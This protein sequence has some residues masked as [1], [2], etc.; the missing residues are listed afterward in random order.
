M[1]Q[2]IFRIN[3]DTSWLL[4]GLRNIG[5]NREIIGNHRDI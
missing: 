3:K 1:S 5:N 2:H 4:T